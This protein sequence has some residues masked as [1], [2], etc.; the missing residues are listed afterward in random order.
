MRYRSCSVFV[1]AWLLASPGCDNDSYNTPEPESLDH[2]SHVVVMYI[3]TVG[4][5]SDTLNTVSVTAASGILLASREAVRRISRT[6]ATVA[7][8]PEPTQLVYPDSAVHTCTT[9]VEHYVGYQSRYGGDTTHYGQIDRYGT[10]VLEMTPYEIGA[11]F[12]T[13]ES[14]RVASSEIGP[15]PDTV[16]TDGILELD[17]LVDLTG[18]LTWQPSRSKYT[19][20]PSHVRVT[21]R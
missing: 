13:R 5:A 15:V 17:I 7:Q 2:H 14:A 10:W 1:L 18:L 21:Q 3:R 8:L 9:S 12:V 6:C 16:R 11:T 4:H 20:D 19:F